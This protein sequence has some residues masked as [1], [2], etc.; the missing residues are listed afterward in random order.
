MTTVLI[1][2]GAAP[3]AAGFVRDICDRA[4]AQFR[5]RGVRVVLT[6]TAENLGAAPELVALADEVYELDY[7]DP[8]ACR[9]WAARYATRHRVDAVLGYREYAALSVAEVAAA[10]GLKGNPPA[11]VLR[12][13]TKDVCRGFLAERGFPQ[14]AVRLCARLSEARDF[15]A[16]RAGRAAV[17][18]PRSGSSSEGVT[19]VTEEAQLPG[20]WEAA[21]GCTASIL[22]EEF[23]RGPEFSVEGIFASGIPHVLAVTAK[24][25]EPGTFVEAGHVMPAP[26][27]ARDTERIARDVRGAVSALGLKAGHFHA[28]CWLTEQGVVLG[29]VHARQGGDWI[30]ALLEWVHPGFELYGA[31]LDDL[32]GAAPP[33]PG[34]PLRGGAVRF[35]FAPEGRVAAVPDLAPLRADA[36]VLA[37]EVALAEGDIVPPVSSNLD[38][39]GVLVVGAHTAP[40]AERLCASLL[41]RAEVLPAVPA[42]A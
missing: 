6:D 24:R 9:L 27:P 37:A 7:A 1:I 38:R 42:C 39:H 3:A 10:L 8:V 31:W 32:L 40:Q 18:K 19:L 28:E 14:P 20:A 17:V 2:G 5:A 11:A 4:L 13:R 30:H 34:K 22:I 36:R 35:L 21:G 41:P 23:V 25:T 26:L 33:P 29:E 16:S 12:V 15:L